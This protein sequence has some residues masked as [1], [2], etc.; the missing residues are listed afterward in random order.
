MKPLA[1]QAVLTEREWRHD[2]VSL[3]I[4]GCDEKLEREVDVFGVHL[5][6]KDKLSLDSNLRANL[7]NLCAGH[8]R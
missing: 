1:K 6:G 8:R 3:L 2:D 7:R 4:E 5:N